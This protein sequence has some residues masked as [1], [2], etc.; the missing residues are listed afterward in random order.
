MA[1]NYRKPVPKSQKEISKNLQTPTDPQMGNPNDS[2]PGPQFSPDNQAN[3]P[4]N[5]STKMS[6]KGDTTKPFSI[7]IQ[8][9]DESIMYY[10]TEVIKPSVIQNGERIAVPIIYGSPERW[11][12]VQKDGYYRDKKGAIMN[13]IVMF[14][15]DGLSK[16]RAL[17]KKLDS[18]EPNL[19]TFWQ[20]AYNTQNFYSNFNVLNNR[21]QT[22]QFIAN[23]IPDYV[24]LTYSCI[25]QTYYMEQLNKIVEA[26]NYASDSY[27]GNPERFKFRAAI[28][29]FT[30][31]TELT[32]GKDRLVRSSFQINLYGYIVPDVIQKDV[33]S[34]KKINEKSKI[35]F[36]METT[37]D[38]AQFEANPQTT[39]DGRTR[40]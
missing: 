8:D 27:W 16:N 29:S 1:K 12:S 30:T 4:F 21:V 26:I 32:Q 7:G 39:E 40:N 18:N 15:R 20:K 17:S 24:N 2:A 36:S 13:P 33:A 37:S 28:D 14:K 25:I 34:I 38:P 31:T 10:F 6:F 22:K 11:K 35:I 9:I 23:V 19:Y 3:I 5:R